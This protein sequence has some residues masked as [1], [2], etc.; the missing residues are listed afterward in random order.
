MG[1]GVG[2]EVGFALVPRARSVV[3]PGALRAPRIVAM[4]PKAQEHG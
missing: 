1:P 2:N 4:G 3:G